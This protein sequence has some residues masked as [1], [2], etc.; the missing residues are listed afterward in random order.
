MLKT[1]KDADCNIY[2]VLVGCS[3]WRSNTS[4]HC[5]VQRMWKMNCTVHVYYIYILHVS[6]ELNSL[7][8]LI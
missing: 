7:I 4:K 8:G 6:N 3:V 1:K 5:S 2:M